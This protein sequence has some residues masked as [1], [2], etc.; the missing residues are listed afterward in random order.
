M[1]FQGE[2]TSVIFSPDCKY[3]ASTDRHSIF[4]LWEVPQLWEIPQLWEMLEP[5]NVVTGEIAR[6]LIDRV[7]LN[8]KYDGFV[9]FAFS[10]DNR[11]VA[12]LSNLGF[13][14]LLEI[15][16][17]YCYEMLKACDES[18][19]E[20]YSV[21]FSPDSKLVASASE[22]GIV[23]L[24]EVPE[25]GHLV[26]DQYPMLKKYIDRVTSIAFSPD[27]RFFASASSSNVVSLWKAPKPGDAALGECI[28][29]LCCQHVVE[30][31]FSFD[32]KFI[33]ASSS[34]TIVLWKIGADQ[35][36]HILEGQ[37]A[38]ISS[39]ALSPDHKFIASVSNN[40]TVMLWETP[41]SGDVII[42][43]SCESPEPFESPDPIDSVTLSPD[44]R[45]VAS[46]S[47]DGTVKLWKIATGNCLEC[48][49][50]QL[51]VRS[52]A[53][54][55][56]TQVALTFR[57][58]TVGTWETTTN[59][60]KIDKFLEIEDS[61]EF[62]KFSP[63]QKFCA[64]GF[65]TGI[66]KLLEMRTNQCLQ[67]LG[68][69]KNYVDLLAFSPDSK[70]FAL[71][72]NC[73]TIM[74]CEVPEPGNVVIDPHSQNLKILEPPQNLIDTFITSI[75]CSPNGTL[76]ASASS[77]YLVQAP[78]SLGAEDIVTIWDTALSQCI[79]TFDI[80]SEGRRFHLSFDSTGDY[81]QT[82]KGTIL[83]KPR[84][85]NMTSVEHPEYIG[86]GVSSDGFWITYNS[87]KLLWLPQEYRP[88]ASAVAGSTVALGC[89]SGLVYIFKFRANLS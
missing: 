37:S 86:Y 55:D 31:A 12:S 83:L 40:R 68:D 28:R 35:P 71:T 72:F 75:A 76:I 21:A 65:Q 2:A 4:K 88:S 9:L 56:S 61:V 3:I 82:T 23:R 8:G 15:A 74:L 26:T 1:H 80:G 54:L 39:V 57:D 84:S 79:R 16:T 32:S 77:R 14:Q 67:A 78:G 53:F 30:V 43:Q 85:I 87:K 10:P 19:Q 46:I 38:V 24:W 89:V 11:F 45:S 60:L 59:V 49:R 50:P 69:A 81:L 6:V 51:F 64:V 42:S 25:P 17:G 34:R 22:D 62:V 33:V 73:V 66:V 63:D 7:G 48:P 52:V 27:G 36:C 47:K 13:F 18:Y 29:T 44:S 5:G 41:K 58:G 70:F 20:F